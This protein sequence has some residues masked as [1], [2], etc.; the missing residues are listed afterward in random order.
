MGIVRLGELVLRWC[1][2]CNL[3]IL[4]QKKCSICNQS[5]EKVE[6]TPPGDIRP[7]FEF[8]MDLIREIVSRQFGKNT[9]GAL[10]PQDKLVLLNRA[11]GLDTIDEI[12][13]DGAVV[14][15]L[16]YDI[17][18]SNFKVIM[19]LSGAHFISEDI[20]KGFVIVDSGAAAAIHKGASV[21]IPGIVEVSED[22]EA[23]NEIIILDQERNV[24]ATGVSKMSN[25]EMKSR[26]KGSAI[27]SRWYGDYQKVNR[28]PESKSWD[29]V[30]AA[31]KSELE[32]RI[33]KAVNFIKK[34]SGES[35]KPVIVSFSGG[36]DSLATLLLVLEAGLKPELLFID[37]GLE[38]PETLE[39]ANEIA[40]AYDVELLTE[41]AG[42][43]F[44]DHLGYFGPPGKDFR[45]CCKTCKLGP[46]SK[47]IKR[48]YPD[49]V[50]SFIGQRSYESE[51]RSK[52]GPIWRNPWVPGQYAASP[53]QKW[54]AMHIWLYL[55]SKN[56]PINPWYHRGLDRIGC[57]MCPASNLSELK[58]IKDHYE[59]Y[60]RWE[61]FLSS[62]SSVA[63]LG[64]QW[65]ELG[66]W[67]WRKPPKEILKL[68]PDVESEKDVG[69]PLQSSVQPK[70]DIAIKESPEL[71]K[72]SEI[73][74]IGS[75][76]FISAGGYEDC[77]GSMSLEGIFNF[78]FDFEKVATLLNIIDEVDV[79]RNT[80]SCSIDSK[81][82]L[83]ENGA[84]AIQAKDKKEIDKRLKRILN[85]IVRSKDCVECGICVSRCVNDAL[86]VSEGLDLDVKKCTHCG[87][88][89]GPCTVVDF[90]KD[91]VIEF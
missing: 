51:P 50:L 62:Y 67:R 38:L 10:I 45:W 32:F 35:D 21:L 41:R 57:F 20:E 49:G 34:I 78:K 40:T 79:D 47:I 60:G 16:Y 43:A 17:M 91:N 55:F 74:S 11:P 63:H 69:I 59:G 86:V 53:I 88:C 31:N 23:G 89:L 6:V 8:D 13:I 77:K 39:F 48:E 28:T 82:T 33:N 37:T 19:R 25:S 83:F 2:H 42:N 76:K 65:H 87:E 29:D 84:L 68:L 36:K 64:E 52:K 85:I 12:I 4:R 27:K 7:A 15:S 9:G 22:I 3:P 61:D 30:L 58:L 24:V 14:G 66:L 70:P 56:A 18:K 71:D 54:T 90:E 5:T 81:I 72:S 75:Y 44:W 73:Y 26:D 1:S 46:A 80:R